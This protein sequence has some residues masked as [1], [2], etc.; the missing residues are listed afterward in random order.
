VLEVAI[1]LYLDEN[2]TP[3][4]AT[5]LKRRG[6]NVVTVRDLG[7]LGDTDENHLERATRMEYVLVTS[8]TDFLIM[9]SEG[10]EHTGII[11]GIQENNA[12][13][14]WVKGLELICS[15]YIQEDM[16]NH[17]EFL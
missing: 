14:D 3:K 9:A 12:I 4:I 2:L 15:V 8:D 7:L 5:Q 1:S 17:V 16:V 13:G 10:I 6:I 11:F